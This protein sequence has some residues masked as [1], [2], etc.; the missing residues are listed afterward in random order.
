MEQMVWSKTPETVT[1]KGNEN[2]VLVPELNYKN[3]KTLE[4]M[5]PEL[6]RL[7]ED[8]PQNCPSDFSLAPLVWLVG[9]A[10]LGGL[11]TTVVK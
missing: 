8:Y 7:T 11:V 10:I 1:K 9:G 4:A 5:A 3:Y 6:V 2:Y